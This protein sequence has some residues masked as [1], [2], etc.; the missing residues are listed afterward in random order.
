MTVLAI[1]TFGEPCLRQKCEEV[2]KITPALLQLTRDMTE[3]M[4]AAKGV[5]LA[6]P[7]IG[8]NKKIIVVDVGDV[9]G[10]HELIVLFNARILKKDGTEVMEEG[11]LSCPG[12]TV[13]VTRAKTIVV[14]GMNQKGEKVVREAHGFIARALQHEI[15]HIQGKLIIDSAGILQQFAFKRKLKKQKKQSA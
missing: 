10:K 15:D 13:S 12:I 1:K 5:G 8:I 6:A 4:Y 7:Q 11:C 14:E 3:T 2:K 9:V